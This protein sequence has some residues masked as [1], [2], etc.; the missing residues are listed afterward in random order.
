MKTNKEKAK[1]TIDV[2]EKGYQTERR[3]HNGYTEWLKIQEAK[4]K[5]QKINIRQ[6]FGKYQYNFI[7]RDMKISLIKIW[8][9]LRD[10]RWMWEIHAFEDKRLFSDT[11]KFLTKKEAI[12]AVDNYLK[13]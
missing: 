11:E 4:K 13:D 2:I 12:K 7:K 1:D 5:G 8:D 3:I 6:Y 10:G 9:G